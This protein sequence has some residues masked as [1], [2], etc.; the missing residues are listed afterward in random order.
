MERGEKQWISGRVKGDCS[1]LAEKEKY[2]INI[3]K[4]RKKPIYNPV[5]LC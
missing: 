1:M 4:K 5:T 3:P 2:D